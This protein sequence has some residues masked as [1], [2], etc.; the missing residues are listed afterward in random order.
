M[1]RIL[2]DRKNSRFIAQKPKMFKG[3]ENTGNI[4][5]TEFTVVVFY[6][7]NMH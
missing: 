1:K 2:E 6:L 7:C 4:K 3:L 5:D